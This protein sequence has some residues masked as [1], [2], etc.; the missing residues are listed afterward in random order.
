MKNT[1]I[2][3]YD[4]SFCLLRSRSQWRKIRRKIQYIC[5]IYTYDCRWKILNKVLSRKIYRILSQW[6]PDNIY[7]FVF[8]SVDII[9][10]K[11][12]IEG[13]NLFLKRELIEIPQQS[14][15]LKWKVSIPFKN[16]RHRHL[17]LLLH[18]NIMVKAM[19]RKEI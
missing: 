17:L 10:S 7:L 1:P 15:Y 5:K 16:I 9:P 13:N 11:L 3:F 8:I 19:S 18:L 6:M 12:A 14:S 2:Y 4:A